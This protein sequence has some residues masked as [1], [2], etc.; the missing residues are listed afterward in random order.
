M[1]KRKINMETWKW[2]TR[3]YKGKEDNYW[4]VHW[5]KKEKLKDNKKVYKRR[6]KNLEEKSLYWNTN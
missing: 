1:W 6:G 5:W 4:D 3:E 2:Y